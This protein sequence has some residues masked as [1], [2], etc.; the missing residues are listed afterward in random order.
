MII[1]NG[2]VIDPEND[3]VFQADI[4][5]KDGKIAK[6]VESDNTGNVDEVDEWLSFAH[7]DRNNS[8]EIVIDATGL[9]VGPG[10]CDTHVHFRD[11]GFTHKEDINTG[12]EAAKAGGYTSIV[13]MANTNPKVDNVDTLKYVLNKGATTGINI[14]SCANVTMGMEGKELTDMYALK[15]VGA[16]GFTDD[17][18]PLMDKDIVFNAMQVTAKLQMPISFHEENK[19]LIS[20]NGIN[21]GMASDYYHVAGSPKEAEISMIDRDVKIAKQVPSACVVIQHISTKEGVELVRNAKNSG[22]N[23]HAEATPHHFSLTE[24][25]AIKFGTNAKMNPPLR[26]EEDRQAIVEGIKDGTIDIIATDHAPHSFEEKDKPMTEAPSGIIGLETA[27][28]L[29]IQNL[30][31][32]GALTYPELF[33][34]MSY[35]PCK[36]YN[37]PGGVIKEGAPADFVIFNPSEVWEV[38]SFKSKSSNSPFLG[39]RLPGV[40]KY[41]I[42]NGKAVYIM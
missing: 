25:D 10:L 33:R 15:S 31:N 24:M 9:Y 37:L 3:R 34:R 29:A 21:T 17:G 13:L 30:V 2:N 14:Y 39:K 22:I 12:A 40:I 1:K 41:T 7:E 5:I 4:Y 28:S 26:T 35:T 36:L 23:V 6:I 16:V 20:E 11:P 42:C 19:E 38:T 32:R 27:F 18:I 8:S